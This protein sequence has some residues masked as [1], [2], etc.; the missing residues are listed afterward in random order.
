[1]V[2]DGSGWFVE[3][4]DLRLVHDVILLFVVYE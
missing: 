3:L 4:V 2:V 1:M